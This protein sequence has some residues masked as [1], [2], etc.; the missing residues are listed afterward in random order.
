MALTESTTSPAKAKRA[1]A[2]RVKVIKIS[3]TEA[4]NSRAAVA[5]DIEL[6]SARAAARTPL[7]TGTSPIFA[8][9]LD[10]Q[11][12]ATAAQ[13]PKLPPGGNQS[14]PTEPENGIVKAAGAEEAATGT[15]GVIE[16]TGGSWLARKARAVTNGFGSLGRTSAK[17]AHAAGSLAAMGM[18][19]YEGTKLLG[20]LEND[21]THVSTPEGQKEVEKPGWL[22]VLTGSYKDRSVAGQVEKAYREEAE[23]RIKAKGISEP[24]KSSSIEAGFSDV[25]SIVKKGSDLAGSALKAKA[26]EFYDPNRKQ[27]DRESR[28]AADVA[29]LETGK[30]PQNYPYGVDPNDVQGVPPSFAMVSPVG[31]VSKA[32]TAV[33]VGGKLWNAVKAVGGVAKKPALLGGLMVGN[34]VSDS[35]RQNIAQETEDKARQYNSMPRKNSPVIL[36]NED[37]DRRMDAAGIAHPT[38]EEIQVIVNRNRN[39][40]PPEGTSREDRTKP[41][42]AERSDNNRAKLRPQGSPQTQHRVTPEAETARDADTDEQQRRDAEFKKRMAWLARP[43]DEQ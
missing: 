1:P 4:T 37:L 16:K 5:G 30:G 23:R 11:L 18:T 13:A 34:A 31:I 27:H 9:T 8:S 19:F 17:A 28:N 24:T 6:S 12:G 35:A 25:A 20:S 39:G 14:A 15:A 2:P 26:L 40:L 43:L 42:P 7:N 41:P 22:P 32:G 36:G 38:S 3:G 33:K 29:F 10:P 21:V